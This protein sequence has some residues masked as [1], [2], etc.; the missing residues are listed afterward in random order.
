MD[1]FALSRMPH[2]IIVEMQDGYYGTHVFPTRSGNTGFMTEVRILCDSP[3][4]IDC[5]EAELPWC[6]VE[7]WCSRKRGNRYGSPAYEFAD[8]T[9]IPCPDSLV[10]NDRLLGRIGRAACRKGILIGTSPVP[11]PPG[12]RGA[13]KAELVIYDV[14]GNSFPANLKVEINTPSRVRKLSARP[15]QHKALF[16]NVELEGGAAGFV[17][18]VPA[19]TGGSPDSEGREPVHLQRVSNLWAKQG[20]LDGLIST[21]PAFYLTSSPFTLYI[22]GFP[23]F[24]WLHVA[25]PGVHC[26]QDLDGHRA[27]YLASRTLHLNIC[28]IS[29]I[30]RLG[31]AIAIIHNIGAGFGHRP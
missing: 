4:E 6:I 13:V 22:V 11:I 10:I 8:G 29:S 20:K 9:P 24:G 17:A 18:T 16:D 27:L 15:Q 19:N 26:Q 2:G 21:A 5:F 3:I 14:W 25:S 12:L 31:M 30:G 28:T 7:E 1:P 23:V